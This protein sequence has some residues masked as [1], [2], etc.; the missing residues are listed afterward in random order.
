MDCIVGKGL[1][2]F[3]ASKFQWWWSGHR[4]VSCW[5]LVTE[6]LNPYHQHPSTHK[7]IISC[8]LSWNEKTSKWIAS[9]CFQM[10]SLLYL[11]FFMTPMATEPNGSIP[12]LSQ[13]CPYF[14]AWNGHDFLV[15]LQCGE[16]HPSNAPRLRCQ[17]SGENYP[18][19]SICYHCLSIVHTFASV[20]SILVVCL[21]IQLKG[22]V[23]LEA[24]K[25]RL[26][27][28]TRP[29]P[30]HWC[31]VSLVQCLLANPAR[32]PPCP[33]ELQQT[34]TCNKNRLETWQLFKHLS[35]KHHHLHHPKTKSQTDDELQHPQLQRSFF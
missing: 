34:Q 24:K 12:L 21:T 7:Q 2:A 25:Y 1:H 15:D 26:T 3:A 5:G 31:A 27:S 18:V 35:G 13:Y 28:A 23:T 4:S 10:D 29:L 16:V 19:L 22:L 33:L 6:T 20:A 11:L 8:F 17:A 32:S 9:Y 30:S 14:R